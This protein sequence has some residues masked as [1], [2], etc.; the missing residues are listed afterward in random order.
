MLVSERD[1]EIIGPLGQSA[2]RVAWGNGIAMSDAEAPGML[3]R[4]MHL[5][6]TRRL[7]LMGLALC[8]AIGVV[9]LIAM[10]ARSDGVM[11]YSCDKDGGRWHQ[12]HRSINN[13]RVRRD[14]AED[15]VCRSIGDNP[16]MNSLDSFYETSEIRF[17]LA[18]DVPYLAVVRL[19]HIL[20]DNPKWLYEIVVGDVPE[21]VP[22]RTKRYLNVPMT[23]GMLLKAIVS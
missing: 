9:A 22:D 10:C 11:I 8:A 5:L 18:S 12:L 16:K 13:L 14:A 7:A 15:A 3:T 6:L 20:P 19:V 4:A 21:S 17:F 2:E 23:T 1:P